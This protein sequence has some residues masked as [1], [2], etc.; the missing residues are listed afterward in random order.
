VNTKKALVL[1]TSPSESKALVRAVGVLDVSTV[2]DLETVVGELLAP[3]VRVVIDLAEVSTC[4]STGLGALVRLHRRGE[5]L[6][7]MVAL[8]NPR[9]HVADVLSMSGIDKVLEVLRTKSS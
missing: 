6:G 1:T 9:P 8:Q 2:S 4:D 5:R 7:A 3:G